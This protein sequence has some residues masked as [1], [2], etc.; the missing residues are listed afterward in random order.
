MGLTICRAMAAENIRHLNRANHGVGS[1]AG[2]HLEIEPVERAFGFGDG[3]G[4]HLSV[5]RRRCHLL[6]AEQHLDD[7]QIGPRLQQVGGKAVTQGVDGD[8]L[9]KLRRLAR[10]MAG[11]AEHLATDRPLSGATRKQKVLRTDDEPVA[12]Q[13]IQQLLRQHGIALVAALAGNADDHAL[14]SRCLRP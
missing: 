1:R 9:S 6:M 12:A 3:G 8:R 2:R 5:Q 14:G 4:C 13:D 10:Q 7:A 11:E